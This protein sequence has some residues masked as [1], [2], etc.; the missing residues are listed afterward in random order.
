MLFSASIVFCALGCSMSSPSTLV[1]ELRVMA[2][3]T[4]PAELSPFDQNASLRL[5]IAE[6]QNRDVDVMYWTCTNAGEGCIEA[7]LFTQDL[8]QWPQIFTRTES[9]T[10]RE[11]TLPPAFAGLIDSV[12]QDALPFLGTVMWVFACVQKE[13]SLIEEAK[14]GRIDTDAMSNPFE[15]MGTLPFG[16]ASMAFASVPISNRALEE[17][18]QN[19]ELVAL[20]P[21]ERKQETEETL[22]LSF[23]YSLRAAPNE[24]S[25]VY[26]YTTIGGFAESTRSNSQLQ[27]EEGEIVLSWFAPEKEGVGEAYVVLE[28][29]EGGTAIWYG[30]VEVS[31]P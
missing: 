21:Q 1:D 19:P 10:E 17:R 16:V 29:G 8:A 2:I 31:N 22:A 24:D 5:L 25:L 7:D 6:P 23:S 26:G 15:V 3:Q 11:I 28:N 14:A 20:S 27:Q 12:P 9:L 13:C 4:D 18:I 30:D